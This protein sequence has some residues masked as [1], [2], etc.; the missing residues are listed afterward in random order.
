MVSS[1]TYLF[2]YDFFYTF[3]FNVLIKVREPPDKV[4]CTRAETNFILKVGGMIKVIFFI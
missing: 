2:A 3:L 4:P 1:K